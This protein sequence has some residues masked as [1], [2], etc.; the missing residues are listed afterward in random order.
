MENCALGDLCTVL[1]DPETWQTVR[2]FIQQ[3]DG[4][5]KGIGLMTKFNGVKSDI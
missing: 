5:F 4:Y 3:S 2:I 1:L